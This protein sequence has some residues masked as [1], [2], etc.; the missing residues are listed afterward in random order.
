[1]VKAVFI[2]VVLVCFISC[3]DNY[4]VVES[5]I[6]TAKAPPSQS[7]T[8]VI[9]SLTNI[10]FSRLYKPGT[11]GITYRYYP[12]LDIRDKEFKV[13]FSGRART[14]YGY[15][16][17]FIIVSVGSQKESFGWYGTSL[18]YF[19]TDVN[20]WCHFKDSVTFKRESWHDPYYCINVFS[21][22]ADSPSEKFDIDTLYVQ[23]KVKD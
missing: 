8:I 9:D 15:S 19:F 21:Q 23:V 4:Q 18:R 13:V 20:S 5:K 1:M 17:A 10:P 12:S 14:N 11:F 22:L 7:D 16:N 3:D 2:I 6:L